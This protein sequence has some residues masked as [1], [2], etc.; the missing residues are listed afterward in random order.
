MTAAEASSPPSRMRAKRSR[1]S[2][3][4]IEEDAG[5]TSP[6]RAREKKF[7]SEIAAVM[8]LHS[9]RVSNQLA[10][11]QTEL[12]LLRYSLTGTHSD[13]AEGLGGSDASKKQ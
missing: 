3:E 11:L 4:E 13:E 5:D 12:R 6:V 10:G 2:E 7:K 8:A 9:Q 1:D